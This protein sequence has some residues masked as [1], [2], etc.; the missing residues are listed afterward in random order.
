MFTWLVCSCQCERDA[1][2]P[3]T[4][5]SRWCCDF[6]VLLAWETNRRRQNRIVAWTSLDSFLLL[7]RKSDLRW[8]CRPDLCLRYQTT[9]CIPIENIKNKQSIDEFQFRVA[10]KII[11]YG[12]IFGH[13]SNLIVLFSFGQ[14]NQTVRVEFTTSWIQFC[15]LVFGQFYA[16]RIDGYHE[17]SS[18]SLEL[19]YKRCCLYFHFKYQLRII[20]VFSSLLLLI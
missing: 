5:L 12:I 1:F 15:S 11:T 3:R 16:E 20:K 6:P 4:R 10:I 7:A 8:S 13:H 18:I 9:P 17:C 14:L 19:K 2:V